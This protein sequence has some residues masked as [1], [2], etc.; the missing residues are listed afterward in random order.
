MQQEFTTA[1]GKLFID[2]DSIRI[3]NKNSW[4]KF[5]SIIR[6][7]APLFFAAALFDKL[8][9]EPSPKRNFKIVIY[10][11]LMLMSSGPLIYAIFIRN[12]SN[13]IPLSKIKSYK[14]LED[15]FVNQTRVSLQLTSGRGQR[16]IFLKA[17]DEAEHFTSFLSELLSKSS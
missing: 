12:F 4:Q 6:I 11:L 8:M 3:V 2:D 15:E 10:G 5:R 13:R 16:I 17:N 1:Y 7:I 9:Q 14:I